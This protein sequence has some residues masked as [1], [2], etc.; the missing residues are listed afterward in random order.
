MVLEIRDR[1]S[2]AN[3]NETGISGYSV[4]WLTRM[5][6]EHEIAGS[7]PAIQ[8]LGRLTFVNRRTIMILSHAGI[9]SSWLEDNY[10]DVEVISAT[11]EVDGNTYRLVKDPRKDEYAIEE[12]D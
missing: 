8:T 10:S 7:N 9:I 11:L 6:W 2:P 1:F 3:H 12:C 5:L 4:V